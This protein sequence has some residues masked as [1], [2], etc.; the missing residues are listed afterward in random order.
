MKDFIEDRL[1]EFDEKYSY[2]EEYGIYC[3]GRED[4]RV[5][6]DEIKQ[7]IKQSLLS[8]QDKVIEIL[9]KETTVSPNEWTETEYNRLVGY[10]QALSDCKQAIKNIK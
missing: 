2:D 7:F 4:D 9:P 3:D 10:N 1:E 5:N 8:Y 6:F